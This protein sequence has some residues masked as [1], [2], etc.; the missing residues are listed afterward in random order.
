[1]LVKI[2]LTIGNRIRLAT[3]N[4]VGPMNT[5]ARRQSRPS[6]RCDEV[7]EDDALDAGLAGAGRG[8]RRVTA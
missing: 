2:E 8:R 6:R 3:S 4:S 5:A 7:S 1:M